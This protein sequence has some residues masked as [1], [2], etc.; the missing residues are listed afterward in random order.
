[1]NL[2]II[3]SRAVYGIRAPLIT[4]EAH[5]SPG[6][7]RFNIVGLAEKAVKESKDRVR[8]ALINVGFEFPDCII[9]INLGPAD[10]PKESGR[11]DLPI[12]LGILAASQQIPRQGLDHYEFT[13]ELA[14]SG[15]LRAV[16]GVL[17]MVLAVQEAGHALFIPARNQAEAALVKNA[18]VF[19]TDHLLAICAHLRG[20]TYLDPI[21]ITDLYPDQHDKADLADIKGQPQAKRALTIAAAGR[22]H[23]LLTG[24]PGTGKTMLASRLR[25][26]LPPLTEKEALEVASIATISAT[27]FNAAQWMQVPFRA[28]HHTSSSV[29]LVGGGRPPKPGEI[30]LAHCGVLFLDELPEFARQ[31]LECLREPLESGDIVISRASHQITFP[32]Q[33]QLIAAMNPCPC[34]KYGL[35]NDICRCSK[36]QVQRYHHKISAPFLDR[37]DMQVEVNQIPIQLMHTQNDD[38]TSSKT[39]REEV[40]ACRQLQLKRQG[41]LNGT[42]SVNELKQHASLQESALKVLTQATQKFSLSMRAYHRIIKIALTLADFEQAEGIKSSHIS[43]A[44][45]FRK[46]DRMKTVT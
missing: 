3:N 4:V 24:P 19:A 17:P 16:Q 20:E 15:E 41:K 10:L 26:I 32:A 44:L 34:G 37:I 27:G 43:E 30:S 18:Q 25:S 31:V 28:P 7:Y 8:S 22:H 2:A 46:F 39:V 6:N 42:L 9:T 11:F 5:L 40:I 29:A 21:K 33:F 13:G 45:S 14:L 1:M 23:L 12:A 36:D 35:K 38:V